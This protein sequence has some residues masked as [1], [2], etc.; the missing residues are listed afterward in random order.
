MGVS[1]RL[2]TLEQAVAAEP[3][4]RAAAG[5][6]SMPSRPDGV[7]ND[8]Y[9]PPPPSDAWVSRILQFSEGTES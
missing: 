3:A 1:T 8:E 6:T 7:N 4:R 2:L 5:R 9:L